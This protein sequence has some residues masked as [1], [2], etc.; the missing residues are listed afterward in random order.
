MDN[1]RSVCKITGKGRS[2]DESLD[3]E[4]PKYTFRTIFY[5]PEVLCPKNCI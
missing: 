3:G 5:I 4:D 1:L 2:Q